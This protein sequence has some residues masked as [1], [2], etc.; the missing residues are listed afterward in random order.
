MSN[1]R[2]I[3]LVFLGGALAAGLALRSAAVSGLLL[4]GQPDLRVLDLVPLSSLI[5]IV[6][7]FI[8]FFALFRNETAVRYTDEAIGELAKVTWPDRE[9]TLN[10]S[11][12]VIVTTLIF[13]GS[14]ALFDFVWARVTNIF[15]FNV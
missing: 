14:L 1:Q 11:M 5:A 6:G 8:T 4:A 3:F 9:E 15:L 7:A 10:S 12:I 13:S 2:F